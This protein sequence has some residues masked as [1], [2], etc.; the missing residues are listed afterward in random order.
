MPSLLRTLS[1]LLALS[2]SAEAG[3][4]QVLAGPVDVTII[5]VR[6]GDSVDVVAHVWPGHDVRVSVR[7][8]SIDAPELRARCDDELKLAK[9]ARDRL[10]GLLIAGRA[11]LRDIS[12]GKYYGRVLARLVTADGQDV[13]NILLREKLVRAYSGG[14]RAGWCGDDLAR[15]AANDF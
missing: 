1:V 9:A 2:T 7:L 5:K 8:R 14:K 4:R 13:Q 6:D 12:G 10:A 3:G 15:A 11:Q